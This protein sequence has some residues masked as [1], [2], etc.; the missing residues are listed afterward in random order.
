MTKDKT[1][2]QNKWERGAVAGGVWG[3]SEL[4]L[5]SL[6]HNLKVPMKGYIMASI[7]IAL[8]SGI[9][10]RW[11]EQGLFWRAGLTAAI[12]KFFSPSHKIINPAISISFEGCLMEAGQKILGSNV[13]GFA[14]GG[15]LALLYTLVHKFIRMLMMY[16]ANIYI[17]YAT[18][19]EETA[20]VTGLK[21]LT[22][23]AGIMIIASVYA[24]WGCIVA[25]AGY[26]VGRSIENKPAHMLYIKEIPVAP[27]V[28]SE[29]AMGSSPEPS[30]PWMAANLIC[31]IM[32]FIF[33]SENSVVIPMMLIFSVYT[34]VR[35]RN[36]LK[37]FLKLK[38]WLPIIV[39]S[40][41][42]GVFIYAAD[43]NG[44]LSVVAISGGVRMVFR[45]YF[46]ALFITGITFEITHPVIRNFIQKRYG[47]TIKTALQTA[48]ITRNAVEP[49]FAGRGAMKN[50]V[51]TFRS[52]V[53]TAHSVAEKQF[54][55][56]IIVTGGVNSGKTTF[57]LKEAER[58]SFLGV[59]GF[60]AFAHQLEPVKDKYYIRNLR[61][62][63][64]ELFCQRDRTGKFI[65]SETALQYGIETVRRDMKDSKYVFIDEAG[66][67]ELKGEGWFS[68]IKEVMKTDLTVVISV[69]DIFL[70]DF[71]S[72]FGI[73]RPAVIN[74]EKI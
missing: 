66:K 2:L 55:N 50:P 49:I 30:F 18:F 13:F 69:R 16:G 14:L 11:R 48:G 56:V 25:V 58:L 65:F 17:L 19:I 51:R 37:K 44:V 52:L 61:S 70:H 63:G 20:G 62:N 71:V 33:L 43:G 12:L 35:Y 34:A 59:C 68:L 54:A 22:P 31:V 28:Q 23:V 39:I 29:P 40:F 72:K 46:M 42:S 24:V 60:C 6:L 3:T 47:D 7:G 45:A 9:N 27:Q 21:S 8:L 4:L 64:T 41:L 67:L 1:T 57:M 32:T 74:V 53:T 15:S 73:I 36:M 5:G 10:A 38:F 26:N